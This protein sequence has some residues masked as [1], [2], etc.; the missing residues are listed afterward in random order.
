MMGANRRSNGPRAGSL[1]THARSGGLKTCSAAA[2]VLIHVVAA[3]APFYATW[4]GV[5]AFAILYLVTGQLG[6]NLGFHRLLAHRSFRTSRTVERGLA[7]FGTLALQIGPISWVG[8][9]RYHH[10]EADRPLDPHTPLAGVAW[11]HFFWTFYGHPVLFDLERRTRYARDLA[12]DPFHLA[13]ERHFLAINLLVFAALAAGGWA[14]GG[15]RLAASMLVW[16]GCLRVVATWHATFIVNSVNHLWGY[17]NYDTVDNSRNN[18]WISLLVCGEG[19]HN[20]HHAE[21]RSAA[22]GHLTFEFDSAYAMI[23][24]MEA[25]G[26]AWGVIRPSCWRH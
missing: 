22:H 6:I 21:P 18:L 9:H 26:L 19:W 1:A 23:R 2:V 20:N 3:T 17:R 24:L 12:R 4:P 13:L 16:G 25:L 5:M 15:P 14:A 8:N 7:L 10:I 11:A